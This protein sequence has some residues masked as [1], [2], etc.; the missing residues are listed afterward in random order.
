MKICAKEARRLKSKIEFKRLME[1]MKKRFLDFLAQYEVYGYLKKCVVDLV[2]RICK[3][4]KGAQ[5]ENLLFNW[6]F[7]AS[8][9]VGRFLL[10]KQIRFRPGIHQP[11]EDSSVKFFVRNGL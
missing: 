7:C 8:V 3:V 4:G 1:K 9:D 10:F 2:R 5:V 11:L 6:F